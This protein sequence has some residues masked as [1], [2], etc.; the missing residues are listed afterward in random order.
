MINNPIR[1]DVNFTLTFGVEHLNKK[2]IHYIKENKLSVYDIEWYNI[3]HVYRDEGQF[4]IDKGYS[5]LFKKDNQ[6]KILK[7]N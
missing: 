2:I 6:T 1:D 5:A 3:T 7:Y 4:W